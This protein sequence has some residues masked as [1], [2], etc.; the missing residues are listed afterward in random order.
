MPHT[1]LNITYIKSD[2]NA[3]KSYDLWRNKIRNTFIAKLYRKHLRN[4][5]LFQKFAIRYMDL[6]L[7]KRQKRFDLKNARTVTSL[8]SFSNDP[9]ISCLSVV[10][11]E[12]VE[13]PNPDILPTSEAL[14]IVAPH[15]EYIFPDINIYQIA[16]CI[17]TGCTNLVNKGNHVICH[18]MYDFKSDLLSE[19]LHGRITVDDSENAII[20]SNKLSYQEVIEE[21]ASFVDSCALNYA[22]WITEIIPRIA[23]FCG[24]DEYKDIPLI[25]DES[26]HKNQME[27][28]SIVVGGTRK[29]II[30]PKDCGIV[31]SKLYYTSSVGYV[32]FDKR[33]KNT[34]PSSH[35]QFSPF[36]LSKLI[37]KVTDYLSTD[38]NNNQYKKIYIKRNS[39]YR[40]LTNQNKI[41]Q[42]L[43]K[44]G[45]KIIEPEKLSFSE[46]VSIFRQ[47]DVVVGPTG[48]AFAN[49][50]F[51]QPN[52]Q[53]IILAYWHPSMVY[54]YWQNLACAT[55]KRIKYVLGKVKNK[56]IPHS[57]FTVKCE[58]IFDLVSE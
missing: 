43:S 4:I 24:I 23:V 35:G 9:G 38:I 42:S 6:Q 36:A 48:A 16:N 30:L 8:K 51:C 15:N 17:V 50:V 21:A 54:W 34:P 44:H 26:L 18:D 58:E 27:S 7:R 39:G 53:I 19:E 40:N 5:A 56:D 25:I 28:L 32:P 1:K 12:L 45:F 46:Q 14:K 47:A 55:G 49:L 41:E 22:H 20:W 10:N 29:V 3:L 57:D 52:A 31:V 2:D 13:T 37:G 11:K 33:Y